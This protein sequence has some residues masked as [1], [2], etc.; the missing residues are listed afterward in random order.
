M[1]G[2]A[3]H[4]LEK[5]WVLYNKKTIIKS[6]KIS[7]DWWKRC[8]ARAHTHTQRGGRGQS[9]GEKEEWRGASVTWDAYSGCCT[10]N[11][12]SKDEA[13][14]ESRTSLTGDTHSETHTHSHTQ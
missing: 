3:G 8:G 7:G 10:C 14:A 6:K 1:D 9:E 11:R 5:H 13:S 2:T 12:L 4:S